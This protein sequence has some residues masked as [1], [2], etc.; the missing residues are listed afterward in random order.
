MNRSN[1][2]PRLFSFYAGLV[3]SAA[4]AASAIGC[5]DRSA[6]V[7]GVSNTE[8]TAPAADA[9]PAGFVL[10]EAPGGAK[11]IVALKKD[12][13][14]G[15]EVVLRGRVGG[16]PS[17]FVDGRASMQIVDVS[18]KACGEGPVKDE[19]TT[20]WDF[21]C[22]DPKQVAAHSASVQVV[23]ADGKPL[24]AG[25]KGVGG[26][27]PLSEVTVKGTVAKG[28]DSGVLVVNASGIHVKR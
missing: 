17:P 22:E 26:L 14:P 15:D 20:P 21:C 23:G 5:E 28:S 7:Q 25:L 2:R 3:I 8:Q 24:R 13:Q 6:E 1:F 19:C 9:L 18:L 27:K 11:D 12:A 4:L 10:T 16:S